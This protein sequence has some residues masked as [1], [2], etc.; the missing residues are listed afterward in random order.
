M[1]YRAFCIGYE[2]VRLLLSKSTIDLLMQQADVCI[3]APHGVP[4]GA[5]IDAVGGKR[6]RCIAHE[7]HGKIVLLEECSS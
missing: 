5:N 3:L 2:P 4:I 7:H 6:M 1:K